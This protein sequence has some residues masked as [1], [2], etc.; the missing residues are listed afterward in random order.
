ALAVRARVPERVVV[1]DVDGALVDVVVPVEDDVD[2]VLLEE[3]TPAAAH[4]VVA[5]S[6]SSQARCVGLP[7]SFESRATK[8]ASPASKE[9]QRSTFPAPP[10]RGRRNILISTELI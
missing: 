10:L 1:V 7:G 9:N 2:A 6:F 5:R 8:C 4:V 3:R